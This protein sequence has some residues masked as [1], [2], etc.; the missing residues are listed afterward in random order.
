MAVIRWNTEERDALTKTII[1][2]LTEGDIP[3]KPESVTRQHILRAQMLALPED[4][5]R[6][7]LHQRDVDFFGNN[8]GPYVF[9]ADLEAV[10]RFHEEFGKPLMPQLNYIREQMEDLSKKQGALVLEL[11][12]A[13][14]KLAESEHKLL[15][16]MTAPKK[17]MTALHA[18]DAQEESESDE[19]ED[20]DDDDDWN[21]TPR[22]VKRAPEQSSDLDDDEDDEEDDDEGGFGDSTKRIDAVKAKMARLQPK[23]LIVMNHPSES[24][25]ALVQYIGGD[26]RWLPLMSRERQ[27]ADMCADRHVLHV[28][29]AVPRNITRAMRRAHGIKS[30]TSMTAGNSGAQNAIL[31]FLEQ[32][33]DRQA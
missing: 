1:Q 27:A 16:Y 2:I 20:D 25:K 19:A 22:P 13:R 32:L 4:R 8:L 5:W 21:P 17:P 10:K 31:K 3:L 26:V 15:D 23:L 7:V 12:E 24:L 33:D 28:I 18:G 9:S 11:E 6:V 30:F 29:G 14:R